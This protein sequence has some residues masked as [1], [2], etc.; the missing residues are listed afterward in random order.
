MYII[1]WLRREIEKFPVDTILDGEIFT[2]RG[3]TVAETRRALSRDRESVKFL[4]LDLIRFDGE[5][6]MH[7]KYRDR[8]GWMEELNNELVSDDRI[9]LEKVVETK[10]EKEKLKEEL[11]R[12]GGEG[13]I[14]K[15]KDHPYFPGAREWVKYK[16]E[17]TYDVVILGVDRVKTTNADIGYG[18]L[19]YGFYDKGRGEFVEVST[20]G[21][22]APAH[23]LEQLKFKVAEVKGLGIGKSGKIRSPHLLRFR[24]DKL[25]VDCVFDFEKGVYYG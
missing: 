8:R 14:F 5:D 21:F 19:V 22:T 3:E 24:D 11:A 13:L 2:K 4:W 23:E 6:I 10:E 1:P 9:I 15:Y 12:T 17:Y 7:W 16:F 20:L 18:N 25:P